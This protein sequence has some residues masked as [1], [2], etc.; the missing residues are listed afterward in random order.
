M[1]GRRNNGTFKKG[2]K[3][4]SGGRPKG[5]KSTGKYSLGT[6]PINKYWAK[7][8]SS[9]TLDIDE[10]DYYLYNDLPIDELYDDLKL[11]DYLWK[12]G[13]KNYTRPGDRDWETC[14]A[15]YLFIG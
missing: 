2:H 10:V 4:K 15:Q 14:F 8:V 6:Y 13:N 1:D 3:S 9:R 12:N 7:Q 11:K 5:S